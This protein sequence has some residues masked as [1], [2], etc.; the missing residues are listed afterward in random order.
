M[1][2]ITKTHKVGMFV[3]LIVSSL[4]A[5]NTISGDNIVFADKKKS[6]NAGQQIDEQGQYVSQGAKCVSG[7]AII[8][9][10]NNLGLQFQDH[11]GNNALG[12]Q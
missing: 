7:E 1:S 6:G 5:S 11:E 4:V 2:N 12:Q 10:C 8:F 3:I 9:A